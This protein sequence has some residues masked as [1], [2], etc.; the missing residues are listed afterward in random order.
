[1]RSFL[2]AGAIGLLG[3]R[4]AILATAPTLVPAALPVAAAA[5]PTASPVPLTQLPGFTAAASVQYVRSGY[6]WTEGTAGFTFVVAG[7]DA[8][9]HA[10]LAR[11]NILAAVDSVEFLPLERT[12]AEGYGDESYAFTG[13]KA[14]VS[15]TGYAAIVFW[16]TGPVWYSGLAYGADASPLADLDRVI[17]TLQARGAIAANP[18]DMA[19]L[20][21][22]LDDIPPGFTVKTE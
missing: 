14:E 9:E 18:D 5:T 22:T 17:D 1:M 3:I 7:F 6:E 11:D 19:T 8:E 10:V 15:Y 4:G 16:R 13:S 21:P 2:I 20:L 12:S